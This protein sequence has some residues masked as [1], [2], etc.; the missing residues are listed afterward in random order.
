MDKN[1]KRTDQIDREINRFK[2]ITRRRRQNVREHG[3]VLLRDNELKRK[4]PSL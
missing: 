3:E 1:D 2:K 4:K